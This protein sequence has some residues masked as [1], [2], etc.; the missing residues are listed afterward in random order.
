[1]FGIE[2]IKMFGG[3]SIELTDAFVGSSRQGV[4]AIVGSAG[5]D[6]VYGYD[7]A[8]TH[9]LSFDAGGGSDVFAGGAGNDTVT[10]AAAELSNHDLFSG[11]DGSDL[12]SIS[13]SGALAANA[14]NNVFGF[15]RISLN[16]GG[17]SITFGQ[18][19]VGS[20]VNTVVSVI[21]GNGSDKVDAS[22][23]VSGRVVFVAG[24]GDNTF[25]G[26]AGNDS[27]TGGNGDDF[28][29]G[30]NGSDTL[31]GGVGNNREEG[32]AGSD[33]ISNGAGASFVWGGADKDLIY[34]VTA[35]SS[36]DTI[37]YATASEGGDT[38]RG[39][40]NYLRGTEI[41]FQ[42]DGAAFNTLGNN[43]DNVISDNGTNGA[44]ANGADLVVYNDGSGA[45]LGSVAAVDKYFFTNYKFADSG[46][47]LLDYDPDTFTGV[48]YYDGGASSLGGIKVIATLQALGAFDG[49]G[50]AAATALANNFSFAA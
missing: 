32:G 38:V 21:G 35:D 41:A 2:I 5:N 29:A 3:N 46:A 13:T 8:S 16:A 30:N 43:F 19:T 24:E 10:V 18:G 37:F 27:A 48:L 26:G 14:F 12:I 39:D 36:I 34:T 6:A 11:G 9:K 4:V 45:G 25:A 44:A 20:A 7:I 31:T 50:V 33:S 22:G 42:F 1:M 23:V 15:E 49:G 17:N 40:L 28:L 47:F